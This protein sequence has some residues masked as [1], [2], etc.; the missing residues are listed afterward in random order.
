MIEKTLTEITEEE[1]QLAYKRYSFIKPFLENEVPLA[2]LAQDLNISHRTLSRWVQQYR[3]NGLIG[4][5]KKK[6]TDFGTHRK[7][8]EEL[9]LFIEGLALK[10]PQ[11]S[12][13]SIYRKVVALSEKKGWIKLG[14]STVLNIVT[15]INP[16]L[17][18]LALEGSKAYSEKY[19]LL[20]KRESTYPNEIWQADHSLLDIWLVDD[21]GKH[22][23]PWLTIIMDDYSRAV[24]GY[25]LTFQSPNAQN[26]SLALRQA[27][28]H[29]T[30]PR[31]H[32]CGIPE[33]FYTD[34]GSDFTSIHL[35]F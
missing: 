5:I 30:D 11:P 14:Y 10:K 19:D 26:T 4:L 22:R 29:K 18:T 2:S 8:R 32:V 34:N 1:G 21:N 6:R 35:C 12:I 33:Q 15:N 9:I 3:Q 25:F 7:V 16:A 23:R 27:I 13:A 17:M 20:Y 31:W 28:W 24:A